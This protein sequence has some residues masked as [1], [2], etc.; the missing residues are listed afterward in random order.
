MKKLNQSLKTIP[1]F[2]FIA[3][4]L[5]F[6]SC[7]NHDIT[8]NLEIDVSQKGAMI[9]PNLFGHNLEHTRK[10]IWQGISAQMIANRKFA[11]VKGDLPE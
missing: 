3:S 10:G 1:H 11:A 7:K 9:S 5:F 4:F 2:I 6:Q 8:G